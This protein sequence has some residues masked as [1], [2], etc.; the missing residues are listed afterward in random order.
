M[1]I[2]FHGE[3]KEIVHIKNE[4]ISYVMEIVEEKYLVHRYFGKT[5][6]EYRGAR[7]TQYFKRGYNTEH[8]LDV[9]YV[10][11]DDFPFEY[12]VRGHGDF[13]IPAFSIMQENGVD[14]VE[15][16]FKEWH[17]IE[18]KPEIQGLPSTFA[19]DEKVKTLEIICEDEIAGIRLYLYYSVFDHIGIIARHQ[20]VKNIGT[21]EIKVK[22]IQSASLEL[23]AK[24][25]ECLTLYGTH[26]KEA[27]ISRV[28]LH[29]GIQRIESTRGASSPQHQPFVALMSPATSYDQGEIYAMHFVYSGNFIAQTEVDQFG[30]VRTQM[31][32][33]PDTFCWVLDQEESFDSPEVILNYS[34]EGLGGMSHNFHR[35]YQNHLMPQQFAGKARPILLNSWEA[36]YYDVSIGK[37]AEQLRI[38]KELGV[39]LFVLDDGWFR[40]DNS[41]YVSMGDWKCNET[42][43]PGGINAV[44][45]MVHNQGLKFGL[46][47]EPEAVCKNAEIFK[48]HPNW[49]LSY[50]GYDKVEGRHEYLF[51]LSQGDVR[52]YIVE[53]MEKYLKSGLIDYIKWDMNRPLTDVYSSDLSREKSGEISH[54][55]IIGL[56]DVL[57]RITRKYPGVLIEGCSSGGARFD[58]GMLYYV[59][60]NWT[61]DNTD[62][63]DRTAIQAGY[64]LLYPPIA[65]GAHVSITPNHQTGRSTSLNTRYQVAKFFNLG[66]ELDLAKCTNEERMEIAEQILEQKRERDWVLYADFHQHEV[67]NQNYVM[68]SVVSKEKD[69]GMVIIFQKFF[70]P[71]TTHGFFQINSLD[72]DLDYCEEES[73]K[74]Y[75][76]DEL[77]QL[78]ISVPLVKEDFHTF[79]FHFKKV[80]GKTND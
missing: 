9:P 62:A 23:P 29:H 67:P 34:T 16:R 53:C 11:F 7:Q 73:G 52:N 45:K 26:A 54:R 48:K 68:W 44:A 49:V 15:P 65:M 38:A 41:S 22:N 3:K 51:D 79:F 18:G 40:E 25:Y 2:T 20:K 24:K 6:R 8:L 64:S 57:E 56:Y 39:E 61:S 50:P 43:I 70:D 14:Y 80:N 46:W 33:H 28:P 55:Y 42:K 72:L 21:K 36:M 71:L 4:T 69:Q 10:S 17:I 47:F 63:F 5:I 1:E 13:R 37:I 78:G 66:Y 58:P 30:N 35:L 76:G 31:G 60:Q 77:A 12:P 75:G 19:D 74:I 59:A 27:N 32:I